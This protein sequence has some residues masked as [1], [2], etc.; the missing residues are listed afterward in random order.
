MSAAPTV[1]AGSRRSLK[2]AQLVLG[3]VL[4]VALAAWDGNGQRALVLLA[5]L[6]P[7]P[8]GLLL[9]LSLSMN[10]LSA[11]KW[12][13]ILRARGVD[14]PL[15]RLTSLYLAGKFFSNFLPSM[16][17]GD[18]ARIVLLGRHT[19][20][21][22]QAAVSVFMERFTGLITVAALA[23]GASLVRPARLH[24]PLVAVTVA[25]AA[26]LCLVAGLFVVAPEWA[27]RLAARVSSWSGVGKPAALLDRLYRELSA[28]QREYR[29]W[30]ATLLCSVAF[31]ALASLSLYTSCRA[32]GFGVSYLSIALLTPIIFLVTAIPVSVNNL[33][34]WEWCVS[35][36]LLESGAD[37]A[38][39]LA[40]GVVMRAVSLCVSLAGGALFALGAHGPLG[41]RAR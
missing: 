10:W 34:W 17:G 9:M 3:A 16:I 39:G 20:S 35:V 14:I 38:Q 41:E 8:V 1:R 21:P 28:F 25:G 30:G 40:A 33:G 31:Y 37:M 4:L 15:L 19:G 22:A 7:E 6:R 26:F 23:V 18:V 13:I 12:G 11:V 36:L 27:H 32:V 5:G 2:L 29:L 24:Q